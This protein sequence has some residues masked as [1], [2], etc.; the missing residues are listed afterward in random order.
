MSGVRF[1]T[2]AFVAQIAALPP[3]APRQPAITANLPRAIYTDTRTIIAAVYQNLIR[4]HA[5]R[6]E[7][8]AAFA[9][10]TPALVG[11]YNRTSYPS[12]VLFFFLMIRRPPRSTLFPYTTLFR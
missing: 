8:E 1:Y 9:R 4:R 5:G 11:R 2:P 6:A 12:N 10:A 7:M 3:I